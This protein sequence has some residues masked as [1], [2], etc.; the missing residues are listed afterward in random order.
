MFARSLMTLRGAA[1]ATASRLAVAPKYA[2][3]ARTFASSAVA[4]HHFARVLKPAPSWAA[5]AVENKQ[6]K[7]ISSDDYK[8]KW[9]VL[10][11]YPLD[12]TFV[13]PTEIIAFS[14]RIEEFRALGSEVVGASVDSKFSHLAW[15]NQPRKEGGLGDLKIPLI[16]DITKNISH[17]YGVLIDEGPNVGVALRGTF[18]IDP[19]GVVRHI[20]VNDTGVGR[21]VDE[22]LRILEAIQF[23]DQH[24]EVCPAG[25]KKGAKT[26]KADPVKSK[27]YFEAVN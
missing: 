14:E 11:F 19:A 13:C 24:G 7:T 22:T 10:F 23:N 17:D 8:G 27:E 1:A 9:L 3:S 18:I 20:T 21:S 4:A 25:W 5:P 6:F 15:I 12:F 16:S 26:M 2:C